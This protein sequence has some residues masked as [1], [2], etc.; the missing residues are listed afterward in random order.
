MIETRAAVAFDA[1]QMADILN[2]I[3]AIGGTT[4]ITDPV[5]RDDI[6]LWMAGFEDSSSWIVAETDK[7]EI[8][9]FQWIEPHK[10]L[11]PQACNIASFVKPGQTGLGVGKALFEA[12]SQAA[13]D[14]GF[15]WINANIREDNDS[16]LTYYQSRGFETYGRKT[17]V[18]L[19]DGSVVNKVLKRYDL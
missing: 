15:L 11:P 3:I 18:R 1:R 8:L 10:D 12:T 2:D 5:S 13:R 4:A 19:S 17:N 9:G 6:Q 16:G 14:L 7:G